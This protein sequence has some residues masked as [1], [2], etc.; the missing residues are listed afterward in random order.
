MPLTYRADHVGSLLRPPDLLSA[1]KDPETTAEQLTALEDR[2]ILRVLARQKEAGL[3][4]FT[5]GEFRRDGFMS[6]FYDSVEGLNN[7][8]D[9]ARAWKGTA[10]RRKYP[11]LESPALWS[12]ESGRSGGLQKLRSIS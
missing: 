3:R 6:G 5:D 12:K 2:H 11:A 10:A 9:I 1:R 7:Q 8:A 4:I